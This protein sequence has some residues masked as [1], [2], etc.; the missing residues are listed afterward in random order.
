MSNLFRLF[1]QALSIVTL[2]LSLS[3]CDTWMYSSLSPSTATDAISSQPQSNQALAD[4]NYNELEHALPIY[5]AAALNPWGSLPME[6]KLKPGD[7]NRA[8]L[9][10][11]NHLR[12]I[13]DLKADDDNELILYDHQLVKAV[14]HFQAR[15]GLYPDGI[16]GPAT[17]SALNI[18]PAERLRQIQVNLQRWAKLSNTLGERYI[19]VNVPEY[20]MYLVDHGQTVLSMKA[21]VGKPERPTPELTSTMTRLVLNPYWNVPKTIAEKDIVPKVIHNPDYLDDMHIKI[22]DQQEDDAIEMSPDEVD[23]EEAATDGFRYHFRQDPGNDNALGRVKF[24][25]QNSLD[26][27]MHDTPAKNLFD[28]PKRAFSSGCIRLEKPFELVSYLMQDDPKWSEEMMQ[29]IL[30]TGRTSYIKIPH[31]TKVIITYVTV[32]SDTDGNLQFRDD[33]Y[34]WDTNLTE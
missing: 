27:Y 28:L 18:T 2:Q 31:P 25:F 26:I 8:I 14:K 34:G 1:L 22:F 23:W 5:E 20:R 3:A 29:A 19:M 21:V 15:N 9:I 32:W 6:I 13:G 12:T 11:R 4:W 33:L 10:L 17:I 24:E 7:R 30:D 16:I